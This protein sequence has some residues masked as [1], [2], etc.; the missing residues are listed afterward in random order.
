MDKYEGR[1]NEDIFIGELL[2]EAREILQKVGS[3][4]PPRILIES[5]VKELQVLGPKDAEEEPRSEDEIWKQIRERIVRAAYATRPYCIRCGTCCASGSPTLVEKDVELFL[6]G[7][8]KPEHVETLRQGEMTYSNITRET[9]L[10]EQEAIKIKERP[11]TKTCVF[12]DE[13]E[14]ACLI[15]EFRPA[16]CRGQECWNPDNSQG[17]ADLPK[18]TRKPL[19]EPT[20]VLWEIIERHEERCS[21]DELRRVI[22]RLASTKGQ[23]VEQVLDM[24]RY[25]QHVREFAAEHFNLAPDTLNFFFGR[26]LRETV[27]IYGLA[28]KDQPDGT[29]LLTTIDSEQSAGENPHHQSL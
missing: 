19:L 15:Y 27:H 5:I 22:A 3:P 8:L 6:K 24:L 28:V 10:L 11:N 16:Q 21:H 12:L 17:I 2:N 23:T 1:T 18:L 14:R 20:G 13:K 25:D 4:T 7:I 26:P 29:F 9:A